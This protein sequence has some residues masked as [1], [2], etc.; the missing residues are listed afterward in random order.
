MVLLEAS[1]YDDG[2]SSALVAFRPARMG[3]APDGELQILL[4]QLSKR[5]FA[6]VADLRF[7]PFFVCRFSP[8]VSLLSQSC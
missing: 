1:V 4:A 6:E 2:Q 8:M 5:H 3:R 7:R